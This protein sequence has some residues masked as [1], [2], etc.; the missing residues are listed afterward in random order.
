M[1]NLNQKKAKFA[2]AAAL[3]KAEMKQVIGGKQ[4]T[5]WCNS[6]SGGFSPNPD[7]S[8]LELVGM[9][10]EYCGGSG[11]TCTPVAV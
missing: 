7:A 3:S 6:G 5:C 4:F 11:A 10:E 2:G 9:M 1:E 8:A